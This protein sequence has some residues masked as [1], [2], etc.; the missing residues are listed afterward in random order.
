MPDMADYR[1]ESVVQN[2]EKHFYYETG[3]CESLWND[4][5]NLCFGSYLDFSAQLLFLLDR[6]CDVLKLLTTRL[7]HTLPCL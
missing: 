4:S 1:T 7:T 3:K 2:T 5:L 6:H